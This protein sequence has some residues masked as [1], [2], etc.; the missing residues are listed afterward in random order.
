M[1]IW[2]NVLVLTVLVNFQSTKTDLFKK[3]SLSKQTFQEDGINPT[4]SGIGL[5]IWYMMYH[6]LRIDEVNFRKMYS[7]W[8]CIPK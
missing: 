8:V 2:L 5:T 4:Q 1:Y 6:L 7:L 3:R